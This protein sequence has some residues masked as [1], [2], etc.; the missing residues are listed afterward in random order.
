MEVDME[1]TK[2]TTILFS[3][4]LHRRLTK[5][6]ARQGSSLGALVREACEQQYGIA[7]SAAGLEA[8]ATL[9]GLHLPVGKPAAMKRES[10]PAAGALLP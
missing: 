9:A 1:L 3:P 2:K 7:G 5:L 4:E 6:A 10:V 8:V